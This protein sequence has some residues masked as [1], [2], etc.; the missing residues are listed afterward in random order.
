MKVY[1][2]PVVLCILDGWG[3]AMPSEYNAISHAKTP[4]RDYLLREYPATVLKGT[5]DVI[6]PQGE[7]E[8][9]AGYMSMGT[10]KYAKYTKERVDASIEDGS[11]F[12]KKVLVQL[13]D[14]TKK[15]KGKIHLFCL[16]SHA[17]KYSSIHHLL[18]TLECLKEEKKNIFVHLILDGIDEA[19]GSALMHMQMIQGKMDEI[20]IGK[21]VSVTGRNW[22]M[23][24]DNRWDKIEVSYRAIVQGI[25]K[26]KVN[27]LEK[28]LEEFLAGEKA[29][30]EM[31]PTILAKGDTPVAKIDDGD[32]VLFVNHAPFGLRRFMSSL[33][34]QSFPYFERK[35]FTS[36]FVATMTE[37]DKYTPALAVFGPG[38]AHKSMGEIISDAG[39]K[40]YYITE[41]EHL[42]HLKYYFHG[43]RETLAKDIEYEHI[44]SPEVPF[45]SKTPGMEFPKMIKKTIHLIQKDIHDFFV[46]ASPIPGMVALDT[47]TS[48]VVRSCEIADKYIKKLADIVLAKEGTL[49]LTSSHAL[50]EELV[51]PL[52][53]QRNIL[54]S[55][56]NVP[57]FIIDGKYQGQA[58]PAGDPPNG[59]LSLIPVSG[60]L[61]DIAPTILERLN[62][63]IP[64]DME[65]KSLLRYL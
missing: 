16:V 8:R 42:A 27:N 47:D 28:P 26:E 63:P 30:A 62:I 14:H 20:G 45:Y 58:G 59:D 7:G 3:V 19:S 36:L 40:Q 34:L 44:P 32:S 12:T 25:T 35:P 52:T 21:I 23:N 17:Q 55:K 65:G 1:K 10:G 48:A 43:G 57:L 9:E 41:T 6:F 31:P 5:N 61:E 4:Y 22:I 33:S 56:N 29:I 50:V 37:Y 11:F 2:K 51:N 24:T 60:Y 15:Q 49:F 38:K 18:A 53:E 64:E 39:L 46:I 13:L 54:A